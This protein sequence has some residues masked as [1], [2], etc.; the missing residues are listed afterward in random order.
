ML[1]SWAML[2]TLRAR[3]NGC[4]FPD[5]ILKWIF[6]NE[7]VWISIRISLQL[8]SSGPIH[9]IP[10]LVQIMACHLFGAKPLFEP[11]MVGLPHIYMSLSLSELNTTERGWYNALEITIL[12]DTRWWLIA[13]LWFPQ[14][15]SN[16]VTKLSPQCKVHFRILVSP[17]VFQQQ[18]CYMSGIL[19]LWVNN[20]VFL[21]NVIS[22]PNNVPYNG[23]AVWNGS[24]KKK[25]LVSTVER[26][27]ALVH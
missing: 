12:H 13:R 17:E 27:D 23:N 8:I 16:E 22:F 24:N 11:M 20:W 3:Q 18:W 14:W 7:N 26:S 19:N 5:D 4:H 15:I 1:P 9:N 21:L 25:H 6:L 10:A 2:N